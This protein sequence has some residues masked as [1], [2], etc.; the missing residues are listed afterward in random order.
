MYVERDLSD[1]YPA[2]GVAHFEPHWIEHVYSSLQFYSIANCLL[3]FASRSSL[4]NLHI[5]KQDCGLLF[6]TA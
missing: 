1:P 4:N 2:P 6:Y 3:F 5:N